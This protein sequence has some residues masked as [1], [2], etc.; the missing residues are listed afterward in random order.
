V[1][2][3]AAQAF[4]S[5]APMEAAFFRAFGRQ[6]LL[7]EQFLMDCSWAFGNSACLGGYQDFGLSFAVNSCEHPSPSGRYTFCTLHLA[8]RLWA[9]LGGLEAAHACVVMFAQA[10]WCVL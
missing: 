9:E 10:G 4:G 7:S 1:C 3:R 5:V 6:Q 2:A 8:A